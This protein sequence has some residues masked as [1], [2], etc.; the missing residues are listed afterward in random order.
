MSQS[1]QEPHQS[2]PPLPTPDASP[3]PTQPIPPVP[4]PQEP[5]Q[6]IHQPEASVPSAAQVPP[7]QPQQ[8]P[9]AA[10]QPQEEPEDAPT[11]NA[12]VTSPVAAQQTP[13]EDF[14][15]M[16]TMAGGVAD[17]LPTELPPMDAPTNPDDLGVVAPPPVFEA[18]HTL[19]NRFELVEI[20]GRG[21]MGIVWK[22]ID[23]KLK[24]EV[25]LKFLPDI[26]KQDAA[27]VDELK[28]ETNRSLD[29]TH[30]HIVRI[31]DFMEDDNSAAIS[32]ELVDGKTLSKMRIGR[33]NRVFEPR[34]I[35]EWV[36]QFCQA[37]DYAHYEAR[38]AHRDLKPANLMISSQGKL[39]IADFG[40]SRSMSNS[41]SRVTRSQ[42]LSG[43]L[44]YMSPQQAMGEYPSASDDIYS[45][46]ATIFE[47]ITGKPPFYSGD[48]LA[49]LRDKEAPY[50]KVR[51]SE[52]GIEGAPIPRQWEETIHKCLSKT[53]EERPKSAGEVAEMLGL[54]EMGTA[55]TEAAKVEKALAP[56]PGEAQAPASSPLPWIAMS[57]VMLLLVLG[58]GGGLAYVILNKD[59]GGNDAQMEFMRKELERL[60]GGMQSLEGKVDT[61]LT[62]AEKQQEEL[63]NEIAEKNKQMEKQR[64]DLMAQMSQASEEE[65]RKLQAQLDRLATEKQQLERV[66]SQK[67]RAAESERRRLLME[68]QQMEQQLKGAA[69][70]DVL[71]DRNITSTTGLEMVRLGAGYWVGK[72]EVSQGQ[73]QQLM[74]VNPSVHQGSSSP[75]DSVKFDDAVEFCRKLTQA[76]RR[77]GKI[78]STQ[79]YQLP[80]PEQWEHFVGD[81][82]IAQS[83]TSEGSARAGSAPVASM[84]ANQYTLHDV[85]GNVWEWTS[86]GRL[87]GGSF[88][89]TTRPGL[90]GNLLDVKKSIPAPPQE[91]GDNIGFRVV[92]VDSAE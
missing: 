70:Q 42:M 65:K 50:M 2:N 78:S 89:N 9:S 37:L 53:P 21:G 10:P 64:K 8:P 55:H 86:D 81:A 16:P 48:I 66:N 41:I 1:P 77:S 85:R 18:G 82:D 68:R 35:E 67:L 15:D 46:G 60:K 84:G 73:Y 13:E 14:E 51:R 69:T 63:K 87:R 3:S 32:M 34:E 80:T 79:T 40:I 54:A 23:Q 62:E 72:T 90:H 20:L 12:P 39:K 26:M 74:G 91:T 61:K 59:T 27:A 22:A 6:P 7:A 30:P 11:I 29:L 57:L 4:L 56:L 92:L 19:F 71:A 33:P 45:L 38:V 5:Q 76:D 58:M 43:T 44:H 88:S 31:Y 52:M 28:A 24:R 25:A 36:R 17:G 49:Q 47:L 75:V 83:V